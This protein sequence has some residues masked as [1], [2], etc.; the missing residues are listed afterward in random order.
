METFWYRLTHVHPEMAVR[1]EIERYYAI[2]ILYPFRAL[3]DRMQQ[4]TC[5]KKLAQAVPKPSGQLTNLA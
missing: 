4:L 2:Y 3:F 5:E 1:T